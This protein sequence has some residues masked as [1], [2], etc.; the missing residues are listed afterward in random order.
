MFS[1][2]RIQ[3]KQKIHLNL[4]EEKIKYYS[5][6]IEGSPNISTIDTPTAAIYL[7]I[8]QANPIH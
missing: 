8:V 3:L 6:S 7:T 2:E 5:Y 4:V 1:Q